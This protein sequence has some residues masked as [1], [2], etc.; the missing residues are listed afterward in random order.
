MPHLAIIADDLTGALD[1]SAPF[2]GSGKVVVATDANAI[3]KALQ[4]QPDVIA[5]STRSREIAVAEAR[6]RVA[7]VLRQLPAETRLFKKIDSRLKGNIA[8]ELEAFGPRHMLVAPAIPDFGRVVRGGRLSGFGIESP[9]NVARV[10]G[11]AADMAVI[12]EVTSAEDMQEALRDLA[13]DT[14]LVGARGLAMALSG[15][16]Q[17][18]DVVF[19]RLAGPIC[20][21]VGSTD[22]IT[23]AQVARLR[24]VRGDIQVIKASGGQVPEISGP[25]AEVTLLQITPGE[26]TS[27]RRAAQRFAEGAAPVLR[28]AQTV[29]MTGGAS[30][31]AMLDEQGID[32]LTVTGEVLPGLPCCRVGERSFLTKS[33]GFGDAETFV[34]LAEMAKHMEGCGN[35]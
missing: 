17:A 24:Q 29:L 11:R 14:I 30:A 28:L 13:S 34:R 6:D 25:P 7:Q 12:P 15:M 35:D 4:E 31:E 9:I 19:D 10:L 8:A 22:P 21:A 1:S 20:F 33:G 32:V 23:L 16:A 3:E 18:R 5:V 26:D 27:A 2:S